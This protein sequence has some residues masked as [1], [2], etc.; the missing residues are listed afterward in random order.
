MQP[1][2]APLCVEKIAG[3]K[4]EKELPWGDTHD[5]KHTFGHTQFHIRAP[6][7]INKV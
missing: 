7:A 6:H 4:G 1:C 2:V 3:E 5:H